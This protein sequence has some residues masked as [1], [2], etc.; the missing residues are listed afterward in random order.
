MIEA[1]SRLNDTRG[2]GQFFQEILL[3]KKKKKFCCKWKQRNRTITQEIVESRCHLEAF[4]KILNG[5]NNM[6][7]C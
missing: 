6:F 7:E 2:I 3:Q 1:S 5:R 4:L